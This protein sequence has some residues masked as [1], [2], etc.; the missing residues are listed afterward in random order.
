MSTRGTKRQYFGFGWK[1][2]DPVTTFATIADIPYSLFFDSARPDH[3][4]NRYSFICWQPFETIE[5][6]D[7]QITITNAEQKLSFHGDPFSA[8]QERL[9]LWFDGIAV[10]PQLPPFKGGAA[11]LFGYDLARDI[12]TLPRIAKDN[13]STPDMAI[14]LYDQVL[15][16]DHE[17]GNARLMILSSTRKE[18][19]DKKQWIEERVAAHQ[20]KAF[21]LPSMFWDETRTEEGFRMDIRKVIEY[22]YAGDMFQA[23]LTRRFTARVPDDFDSY[24]HY[25]ILRDVNPAP[26]SSYMN[27]GSTKIACTSPE[28][29]L[30]V[31]GRQ[32]ETRPIKGTRPITS[33]PEELMNSE[34]DRAE[35]AMIVDL[36]RNDLSRVCEDHSI[37]VPTLCGL[38]TYEGL[39]HLVSVVKGTLRADNTPLDLMRAC[40]PGGSITGAPKVRA[41]E[42]I[43]ELEPFRRGPYCGSLGYIGFDGMMDT[44]IVIRTLVYS[45]NE[46][47]IQTGGGIL[48]ISDP[49]DEL[50]ETLVKASKL[51]ESFRP[52]KK[53]VKAA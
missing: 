2:P 12:E 42:I 26:F 9:D 4:L 19:Q 39:H 49:Q 46:V 24:A 10:D 5:S 48:A 47:Q 38:E 7:G 41:M 11:G 23:N 44:N 45:G 52:V 17:T 29:F 33:P 22:I 51:F 15:A 36:L 53:E 50:R 3:P 20:D 31:K 16:F 13:S 1:G 37:N 32:V 30:Q 8:V 14:G 25:R 18:A 43:E 21:T 40:F 28:R 34:K 27:F 35:N 6:K